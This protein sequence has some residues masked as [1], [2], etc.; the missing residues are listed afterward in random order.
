MVKS[1]LPLGPSVKTGTSGNGGL[2]RAKASK[3]WRFDCRRVEYV[4]M[5][6]SFLEV[7]HA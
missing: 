3:K 2:P 5:R 6:S 4:G 7:S 1:G